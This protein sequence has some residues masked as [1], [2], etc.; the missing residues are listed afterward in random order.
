[1]K[2]NGQHL[3]KYTGCDSDSVVNKVV[4][5]WE[6]VFSDCKIVSLSIVQG[7]NGGLCH[8]YVVFEEVKK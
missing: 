4:S 6:K 3:I 7:N 5:T 2:L 1:M 8:G